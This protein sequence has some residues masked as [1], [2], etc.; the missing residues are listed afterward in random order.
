M[1][2]PHQTGLLGNSSFTLYLS[3]TALTGVA[4]AM[5]QLLL[6]WILIGILELPATQVGA[7]Q[8]TVGIPGI[9]LML[10]GGANADG[11]GAHRLLFR[12]YSLAPFVPLF[13]I[14]I[15]LT[16]QL[17]VWSVL[18]WALGMSVV[19]SYSSP[20]QQAIL[21]GI[22]G[23]NIQRA[24]SAATAIGFVVQMIGLAAAGSIDGLGLIPAL[25]FQ[26]LCIGLGAVTIRRLSGILAHSPGAKSDTA[27]PLKQPS[28][29]TLNTIAKGLKAAYDNKIIFHV[30]SI[31]FVS[32]IFN[33]GA[34]MTVFPFIIKRIYAGDALLLSL[35][36]VIFY[37]GATA[38][39][40][41]MMRIMPLKNPGKYFLLM[42]LSRIAVLWLMWIQ[43]SMGLMVVATVG[44]GLNMGVTMTLARTIVQESAATEFRARIMSVYSLGLLGSAPIGALV[45]GWIIETFGTLNALLPAMCLSLLLFAVGILFTKIYGY[46]SPTS[47]T[48]TA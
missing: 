46:Q 40:F 35:M 43:P 19:V 14:L 21:N 23:E 12:V 44:W 29:S 16:D 15:L 31:N 5:Q 26:T 7:I 18:L 4:F 33:A 48:A 37:A 6:S 34:F 11:S 41:L 10:L 42:Q 32:S 1:T 47:P 8:A 13:L 17:A 9:F 30:L 36:M 3:S 24:V 27:Q 25:S 45:L 2:E 20:A 38:S 39:N 28:G 22:A